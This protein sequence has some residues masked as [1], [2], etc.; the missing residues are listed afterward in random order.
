M[1]QVNGGIDTHAAVHTVTTPVSV[2]YIVRCVANKA[3]VAVTAYRVFNGRA[4]GNHKLTVRQGRRRTYV[5]V[6]HHSTS[7]GCGVDGVNAADVSQRFEALELVSE[8][9]VGVQGR[10]RAPNPHRGR[11]VGRRDTRDFVKQ[12]NCP[13]ARTL[14]TQK[15]CCTD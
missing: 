4:T 9:K 3:V 10:V 6:N 13:S 5:Q 2:K 7:D 8:N 1:L 14:L 12:G 11:L 15:R